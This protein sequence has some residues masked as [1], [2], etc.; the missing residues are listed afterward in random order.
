MIWLVFV[1]AVRRSTSSSSRRR[2]ACGSARSASTRARPTRSGSTSTRPATSRSRVSGMLAAMGGA[3]LSIGF[4]HSFNENMTEG[5]G[6]IALA[7]LIFG[8]WRPF[9]A[10][11][12]ALPVRLL[13]RAR[14]RDPVRLRR[15]GLVGP[16]LGRA[17]PDAPVHPHA[18]AVAGVIGRSVAPAADGQPVCQAVGRRAFAAIVFGSLALAAIPAGGRRR[19]APAVGR[20]AAGARRRRAGRVRARPDR[21]SRPRGGRASSSTAAS[22]APASAPCGF[23]R[24]LVWA[25]LYVALVGGARARLLRAA[26]RSLVASGRV[27]GRPGALCDHCA[28]VRDREQPARG[29]RPP[30]RSTSTQAELATKIR[31]KYLRALEEERFEQLPSQTYVKGFLRTYAEYLGLDGQLYVDE[32][33]S[34]FVAGE[35]ADPRPRRSSVRPE[36]RNRRLETNIVL[37]ALAL[38]AIVTLVVVG[39]WQS[40][41]SGARRR[42]PTHTTTRDAPQARALAAGVPPDRGRERPARTSPCTATG[43]RGQAALPGDDREGPDRAVQGQVLLAQRQLARE[44]RDHRRRQARPR[45]AAASRSS[46]TVTPSGVHV[47]LSALV[48]RGDRRHRL[49][50]RARRPQR[51][52]R[53]VPRAAPCSRSGI[54]PAELRIVGDVPG[55][56]EAALAR[57]A[58]A[59]TC[60]SSRAASGRRTTTGRSSCSRAPRAGRSSSTRSSR[61]RSRRA[62]ARSP[63]G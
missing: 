19:G 2:S 63:S 14:L 16:P 57:R 6:F 60:S 21:R 7:A 30:R 13:D 48:A 28:R 54:E 8:K 3:Y 43:P 61:R 18:V 41:G 23:A 62:R 17:L 49:R 5:R 26:A 20:R 11:G 53:P 55:E 29:A 9:G 47:R 15:L 50:A 35:D 24:F 37:V 34:R 12:A 51:P 56:L 52:Q 42:Q 33:N 4:V 58:C 31:V 25:G 1:A 27:A 44:P 10:F 39:A 46:L 36:R 22:T 59:A 32:F 40:S 45:S 38:V